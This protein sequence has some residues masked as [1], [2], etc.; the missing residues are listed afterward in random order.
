MVQ[1][2][3]ANI[4]SSLWPRHIPIADA[5]LCG[6]GCPLQHTLHPMPD[7]LGRPRELNCRRR[8]IIS[9][10]TSSARRPSVRARTRRRPVRMHPLPAFTAPA[11]SD[12]RAPRSRGGAQGGATLRRGCTR[13]AATWVAR[14]MQGWYGGDWGVYWGTCKAGPN[15]GRKRAGTPPKKTPQKKGR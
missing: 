14:R 2:T 8:A 15:S 13:G 6:G 4:L 12:V 1:N 5:D 3:D 10:A 7:A 11:R 9:A